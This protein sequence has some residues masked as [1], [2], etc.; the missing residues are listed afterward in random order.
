MSTVAAS[1]AGA[2]SGSRSGNMMGTSIVG[3]PIERA[4]GIFGKGAMGSGMFKNI[5]SVINKN[6][7]PEPEPVSTDPEY[8]S[9]ANSAYDDAYSAY[10]DGTGAAGRSSEQSAALRSAFTEAKAAREAARFRFKAEQAGMSP[11]EY[12]ADQTSKYGNI[13]GNNMG[14]SMYGN[15]RNNRNAA[16]DSVVG[17]AQQS[18]TDNPSDPVESMDAVSEVQSNLR[19]PLGQELQPM[20]NAV[21]FKNSAISNAGKM[22]GN[23]YGSLFAGAAKKYEG[24]AHCNVDTMHTMYWNDMRK[25]NKTK[26]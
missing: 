13:S 26:K 3:T 24:P 5:A 2:I 1:A 19:N 8:L 6:Q 23:T 4:L 20:M 7:D 18:Y 17:D 14:L 12:R 9:S 11:E 10:F 16:Y 22:F 25:R 21:G 15:I